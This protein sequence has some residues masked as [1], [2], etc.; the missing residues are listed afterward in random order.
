VS[1]RITILAVGGALCLAA[2][3][4]AAALSWTAPPA[5]PVQAADMLFVQQLAPAK[6]A[7]PALPAAQLGVTGQLVLLQAA[8]RAAAAAA[9]A[10]AVR[11]AAERAAAA[12][13]AAVRAA[14]HRHAVLLAA[15]QAAARA[16]QSAAVT[17]QAA[18]QQPAPASTPAAPSPSGSPEA[19][20]QQQ[21]AQYGWSGQ[22][23]CLYSLWERESSWNMYAQNPSSGAYGIPQALPGSKMASAGSDWATDAATQIRWGLSY[24]KSVYGSPCGA[25]SHEEGYGW[26]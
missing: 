20:A 6:P 4:T 2:T 9:R 5:S 8:H 11:A 14:A 23:A 12:R 10:A 16:A 17:Q 25:W 15:R 1:R 22:Y 13:A 3:G 24:I 19:I 21:L 7:L 26:Y 18:V